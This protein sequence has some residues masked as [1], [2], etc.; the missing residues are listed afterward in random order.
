MAAC[1]ARP[2]ALPTS[3]VAAHW[4]AIARLAAADVFALAMI[5]SY[6]LRPLFRQPSKNVLID[7]R[8]LNR[9]KHAVTT[10]VHERGARTPSTS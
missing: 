4:A 7:R 10:L 6:L 8:G 1:S 5:D 2:E 9:G 3:A